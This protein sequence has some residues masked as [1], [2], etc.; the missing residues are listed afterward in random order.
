[1][2]L[3]PR[4]IA[5]AVVAIALHVSSL[6]AAAP[7]DVMQYLLQVAKFSQ[8]DIT[9]LENG[10]VI[11]HHA[12]VQRF[13]GDGGRSGEDSGVACPDRQLLRPDDFVRRWQGD[14]GIRA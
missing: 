6:E 3:R 14:D 7:A 8:S 10:A 1:M 11:A 4:I 12:G 9:T 2:F 13:R 5:S